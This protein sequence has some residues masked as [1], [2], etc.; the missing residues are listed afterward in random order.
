MCT[1][2]LLV[3]LL[4]P[5]SS[6][7]PPPFFFFFLLSFLLLLLLFLPL[8][9]F[10]FGVGWFGLN[11]FWVETVTK[12]CSSSFD[13]SEPFSRWKR[14]KEVV[15]RVSGVRDCGCGFAK[16]AGC[17]DWLSRGKFA[18]SDLWGCLN[19]PFKHVLLWI[20]ALPNH[21]VMENV[22]TLSVMPDHRIGLG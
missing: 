1:Q 14:F 2:L 7:P 5:F 19:N 21:T 17:V 3:I 22:S 13:G 16:C 18:A 12:A 8:F 9:L 15:C 10:W 20:L 11:C 6:P 4:Y